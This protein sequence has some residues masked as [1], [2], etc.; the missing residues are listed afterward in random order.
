MENP[1]PPPSTKPATPTAGHCPPGIARP[2]GFPAS[3][4]SR[5]VA[6]PAIVMIP[7][8]R[9]TVTSVMSFMLTT[10]PRVVL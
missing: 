6:A 3:A 1:S 8:D 4:T 5:L 7:A 10:S 2:A 9:S